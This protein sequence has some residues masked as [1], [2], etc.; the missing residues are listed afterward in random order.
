[1]NSITEL[2]IGCCGAVCGTCRPFRENQCKGC[3]IGYI[4][5]SR[6]LKKA[7]CGIKVCCIKKTLTTCADCTD[8]L[9]CSNLSAWH[10]KKGYKYGKYKQAIEYIA[11]NGYKKFLS[12]A[13]GWNNAY[14]KYRK[15]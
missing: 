12:M 7:R 1:M 5:K 2:E 13:G 14:G 15:D 6:D 8:R 9:S 10:G 11:E 4:D 3:K